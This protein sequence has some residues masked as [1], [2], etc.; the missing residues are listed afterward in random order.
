MLGFDEDSDPFKR[1][2]L[3]SD[4]INFLNFFKFEI[5]K[6]FHNETQSTFIPYIAAYDVMW[7]RQKC[8]G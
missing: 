5:N 8:T 6:I 4:Y 7:Q 1:R 3:L 2:K